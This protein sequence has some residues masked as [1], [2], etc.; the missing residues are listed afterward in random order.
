MSLVNSLLDN[1]ILNSPKLKE[2]ADDNFKYDEKKGRQKV[3]LVI[4]LLDNK[5]LNSPKLKEF[6]DDN[7]KYDEK[8]FENYPK[9]RKQCG[10]RRNHLLQAISPFPAMFSKDL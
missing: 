9:V 3:S 6:A 4:S 7:F 2:F 1:K 8:L 10:K 5:I